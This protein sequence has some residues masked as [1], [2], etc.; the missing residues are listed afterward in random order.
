[1]AHAVQVAFL[2]EE[3]VRRES[4][5][6]ITRSKNQEEGKENG[7]ARAQKTVRGTKIKDKEAGTEHGDTTS[8]KGRTKQYEQK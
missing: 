7:E 6:D 4:Q 2:E 5:P 1:M 3:D 8:S